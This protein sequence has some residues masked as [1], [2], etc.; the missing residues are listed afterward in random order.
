M[1]KFNPHI[2]VIEIVQEDLETHVDWMECARDRVR[3]AK[4]IKEIEAIVG[5]VLQKKSIKNIRK[6]HHN[7]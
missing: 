2:K 7:V 3:F 4:R 6:R 5:P 1:I